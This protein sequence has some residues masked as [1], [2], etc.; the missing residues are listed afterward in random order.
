MRD[1]WQ[2][3]TKV[4]GRGKLPMKDKKKSIGKKDRITELEQL[5]ATQADNL[6]KLTVLVSELKREIAKLT[7][8][9]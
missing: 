7:T 3:L 2:L 9:E 8:K 4:F 6:S 1:L 5:V